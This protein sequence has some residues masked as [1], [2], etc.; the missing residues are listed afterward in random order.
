M[1]VLN[2]NPDSHTLEANLGGRLTRAEADCFLDEY[3]ELLATF[4]CDDLQVVVDFALVRNMDS[5]LVDVFDAARE[6]AQFSGARCVTFVAHDE[7]EMARFTD[8][9]LQQVLEGCERYVAYRLS[10]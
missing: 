10:A 9:R 1:Y 2:W 5:E 6:M 4:A 8:G 3:N 7:A